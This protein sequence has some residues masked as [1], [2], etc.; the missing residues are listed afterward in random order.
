MGQINLL[1]THDEL[2]PRGGEL[3]F[4]H[5]AAVTLRRR[6][7]E[8]D[9]AALRVF[10]VEIHASRVRVTGNGDEA[11]RVTMFS[12]VEFV[13]D[14]RGERGLEIVVRRGLRAI[15]D[16]EHAEAGGRAYDFDLGPVVLSVLVLK[17]CY[18]RG[19][20]GAFPWVGP[21]REHSP[22]HGRGVDVQV[23]ADVGICEAAA[24]ED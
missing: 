18:R 2:D 14:C 3:A 12:H 5:V 20:D 4:E 1:R 21:V 24:E 17:G 8:P 19:Q 7:C 11:R 15:R 16:G 10:R 6:V 22:D 13:V 23:A 9:A